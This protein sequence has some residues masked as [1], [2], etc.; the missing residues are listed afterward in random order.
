MLIITL[1]T[2]NFVF[3]LLVKSFLLKMNIMYFFNALII[4]MYV[5]NFLKY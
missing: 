2:I 4:V 1:G 5:L 3:V